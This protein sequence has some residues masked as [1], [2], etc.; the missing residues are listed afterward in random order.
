[1][2][3]SKSMNSTKAYV[4]GALIITVSL[5]IIG[6]SMSYAY[7][8]NRIEEVNPDNKEVRITSGDLVMDLATS[9]TITATAVG[10]VNDSDIAT[11]AEHT[12]FSVT[13]PSDAKVDSSKYTIFLTELN[14]S[15][16][17]KSEYLKWA[18]YSVN[19]DA[20]EVEVNSGNFGDIGTK[21][22]LTISGDTVINISK[23]TTTSY[24]LYI[25]LSNDPDNN[26]VSLLN[27]SFSG[28]VGF[29]ATT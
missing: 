16:N 20:T 15:D 4:L 10:L 8:V 11:K 25:W 1:M 24:K 23:G 27:G 22:T 29:R 7:F 19:E 14:I 17:L 9:R 3:S 2:E 28:K 18:L 13:L 26:Q 5:I 21:T 6:V 12:D